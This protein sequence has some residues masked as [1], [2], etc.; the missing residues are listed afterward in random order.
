[1]LTDDFSRD[2]D[3]P[4]FWLSDNPAVRGHWDSELMSLHL[5]CHLCTSGL[6]TS[7]AVPAVAENPQCDDILHWLESTPFGN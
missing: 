3:S 7:L 5:L 2:P 4:P 6:S 1:M